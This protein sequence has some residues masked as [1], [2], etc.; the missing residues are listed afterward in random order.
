MLAGLCLIVPAAANAAAAPDEGERAAVRSV[1]E[2]FF[3]AMHERDRATLERLALGDGRGIAV[4]AGEGAAEPDSRSMAELIDSIMAGEQ[5]VIERIW[6]PAIRIDLLDASGEAG[7]ATLWAPYD[8][9]LD[10]EFHHC[11]I[12]AFHLIKTAGEWRIANVVWTSRT[13]GCPESP[14]GSPG[15]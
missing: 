14:L 15:E 10:G 11:G 9:W 2:R 12:D 8:F 4:R 6:N 3:S 13:E 7:I 5:T 1:V